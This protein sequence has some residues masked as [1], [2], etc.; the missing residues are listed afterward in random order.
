MRGTLTSELPVAA[1]ASAVWSAYRGVELGALVTKLLSDVLGVVETVEGD[2]GVGTVMKVT[3]LPG[4][5]GPGYMKEVFTK[6]DDEARLKETETIEGG[7]LALGFDLYRVRLE[8]LETGEASSV[9]RS[10]IEYEIRDELAEMAVHVTTKPLEVVA[11][12]VGKYVVEGYK[13]G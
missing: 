4:M 2:G 10:S 5:P 13:K 3:F 6:M 9:I 7:F 11:E 8:V 1:P 12:A